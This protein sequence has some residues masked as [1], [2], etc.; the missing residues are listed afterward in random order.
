M[1]TYLYTYIYAGYLSHIQSHLPKGITSH[2][3]WQTS[4]SS[5]RKSRLLRKNGF[6][7]YHM[8]WSL[9]IPNSLRDHGNPLQ[10]MHL[11][12]AA[13]VN[14]H[15]PNPPLGSPY[16]PKGSE[17]G[18]YWFPGDT[19]KLP[20]ETWGK[21][22][23]VESSLIASYLLMVRKSGDHQLS[24]VVYPSIYIC[25]YIPNGAGFLNHQQ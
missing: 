5:K 4:E 6:V 20:G 9:K 18:W 1:R 10:L 15:Q 12:I 23:H 25:F 16:S 24:L 11:P 2:V 21:H 14:L 22:G 7:L 8:S 3:I 17:P 19:E 13:V